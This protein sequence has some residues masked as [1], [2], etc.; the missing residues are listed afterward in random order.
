MHSHKNYRHK[1]I[2]YK[3]I[4]LYVIVLVGISFIKIND[5]NIFVVI[6]DHLSLIIPSIK[7]ISESTENTNSAKIMLSTSWIAILPCAFFAIKTANTNASYL[8]KF[9][10]VVLDKV[11]TKNIYF[12]FG[13]FLTITTAIMA[14]L[15]VGNPLDGHSRRRMALTKL[16][17]IHTAFLSL[18]AIGVTIAVSVFF[19]FVYMCYKS[20][21]SKA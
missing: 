1:V 18:Y 21:R 14:V 17:S 16:V 7:L 8:S 5:G 10:Q 13:L 15:A 11:G 19:V 2:Q 4:A 12:A 6:S 9:K 20:I 3:Y